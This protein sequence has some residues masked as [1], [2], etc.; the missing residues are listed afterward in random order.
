MLVR[1][2]GVVLRESEQEALQSSIA[3][4]ALPRAVTYRF[5]CN[6]CGDRFVL[7]ADMESGAGGWT[8]EPATRTGG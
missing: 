3:S 2:D 4:G 6:L 1:D 8:R 7:D 5:R